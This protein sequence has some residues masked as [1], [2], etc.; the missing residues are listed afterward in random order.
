MTALK[1]YQRLEC[2]GLWRDAPQVQR[3]E[4]VVSFGE[5]SLVLSDPRGAK[6]LSHWSLPA[7]ERLNPGIM[8]AL[9]SPDG[10]AAEVLEL[11]DEIM[12]DA[13]E[14]IARALA[15]A[16]AGRGRLRGA[17]LLISL[18][19]LAILA[20][21]WFPG[22]LVTHTASVVPMAKRIQI[23]EMVLADLARDGATVC[24]GRQ[25]LEALGQLRE[26]VLG[27][28]RSVAVLSDLP[29]AENR[30]RPRSAH[31]PGRLVLLDRV[32][33][34]TADAAEAVAGFMLAEAIR[35]EVADPL[36]PLLEYAGLAATFRLLTTGN[37]SPAAISGYGVALFNRPGA[38]IDTQ[39]LLSR[40]E[41]TGLPST[42]YAYA[43]DP[44]GESVLALI[45]GDPFR[46]SA[47]GRRLLD[48]GAWIRLQSLCS[49]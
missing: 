37:L 19:A 5:A 31:L 24:R 18:L 10:G 26:R 3:R 14:Q 9:Y 48:D 44:S 39:Y 6:A 32:L 40:F 15:R 17:A 7:V 23:G 13:L 2:T 1:K 47:E 36:V 29:V 4:V 49:Q 22:A 46:N 33:I 42:P 45:E 35:A 34:E 11:E 27:H 38:A 8:P 30:L 20:L 21:F 16:R 12:I 28:D 25:G 41:A 43:R